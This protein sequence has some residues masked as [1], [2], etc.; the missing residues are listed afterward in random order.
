MA[1][2]PGVGAENLASGRAPEIDHA[3][4]ARD[5]WARA[6]RHPQRDKWVSAHKRTK[7]KRMEFLSCY[8]RKEIRKLNP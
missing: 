4:I 2:R 1:V 3:R 7:F 8:T 6:S 5:V